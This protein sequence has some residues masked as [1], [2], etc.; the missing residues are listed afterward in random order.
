MLEGMKKKWV[1]IHFFLCIK[2]AAEC[3]IYIFYFHTILS[4]PDWF[5]IILK[6]AKWSGKIILILV[7]FEWIIDE[8]TWISL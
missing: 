8:K 3:F 1:S 6:W 2:I 7:T 4:Y 5:Q